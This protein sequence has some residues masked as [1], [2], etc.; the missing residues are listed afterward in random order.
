MASV[1]LWVT[2]TKW[3]NTD[4]NGEHDVDFDLNHDAHFDRSAHHDSIYDV[5]DPG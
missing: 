2:L 1:E 3:C 4:P 5:L